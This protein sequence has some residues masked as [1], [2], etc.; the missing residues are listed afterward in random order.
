MLHNAMTIFV[1]TTYDNV[2]HVFACE[3][4]ALASDVVKRKE[5]GAVAENLFFADN[6]AGLRH[7][8]GVGF[9]YLR[10]WASCSA[11]SLPQVLHLVMAV[12]GA[13]PL[14]SVQAITKYIAQ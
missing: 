4:A 2:L 10:P 11:C 6:G 8:S 13:A 12:R 1:L 7:E 3:A 9:D 14:D 5:E